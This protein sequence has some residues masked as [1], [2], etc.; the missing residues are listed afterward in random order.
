[1]IARSASSVPIARRREL[2]LAE[3]SG[4]TCEDV[5]AS[6][7][8]LEHELGVLEFDE[9]SCTFD[10]VE[11]AVGVADFKRLLDRKHKSTSLDLS[12]VFDG[13]D[14]RQTLGIS[15]PQPSTFLNVITSLHKSGI[16]PKK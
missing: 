8:F 15:D 16:S 3:C 10:F 14:I 2:L 12:L 6:I 7:E 4:L 1:M 11:D 5:S 13:S 9:H